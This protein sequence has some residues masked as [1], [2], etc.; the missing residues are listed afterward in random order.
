MMFSLTPTVPHSRLSSLDWMSTRVRAAVPVFEPL[1]EPLMRITAGLKAARDRGNAVVDGLG[2]LVNQG[3]VGVQYWTGINPD[4]A[5]MRRAL[6]AEAREAL[7]RESDEAIYARRNAA[8]EQERRIKE[9]EL[10]TEIA[11]QEK[12]RKIRPGS[13]RP[14]RAA[15]AVL[16]GMKCR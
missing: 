11:V 6:E 12:Q 5:V 13:R 1:S 15:P 2:M 10:N 9:S 8:V 7:Q 16:A 3:V 4:P 14:C